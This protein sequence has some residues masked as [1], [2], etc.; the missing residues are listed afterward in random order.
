MKPSIE[1]LTRRRVLRGMLGGGA[2]TVGLPILDCLLD[3]NG[4]A[5]AATGDPSVGIS[6]CLNI[7]IPFRSNSPPGIAGSPNIN[8]PRDA[9]NR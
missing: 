3:D 7:P 8:F 9:T 1:A 6:T 5:F 2:V 4:T